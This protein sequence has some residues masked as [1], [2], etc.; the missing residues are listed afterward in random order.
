MFKNKFCILLCFVVSVMAGHVIAMDEENSSDGQNQQLFILPG[1]Q[2]IAYRSPRSTW[3]SLPFLASFTQALPGGQ[4]HAISNNNLQEDE[5]GC[6]VEP[7]KDDSFRGNDVGLQVTQK[8]KRRCAD[9]FEQNEEDEF[10]CP[11]NCPDEYAHKK[12]Y[13]V[14]RHIKARHNNDFN[15]QTFDRQTAELD[16][17]RPRKSN[18]SKS[19]KYMS[20]FERNETGEYICPY[21]CP[22]NYT[23]KKG[24]L[25]VA[26]IKRRH[27]KNFNLQTFDSTKVDLS[28]WIPC[29]KDGSYAEFKKNE[30]CEFVCPYNCPDNYAHK[31]KVYVYVHIRR[32]H[33]K[34]FNL[35]TFDRQTADLDAWI[36][37]K[38]RENK[39][40][41]YVGVFEQNEIGEFKCPYNCPDEYA[42]KKGYDVVCHI[43]ARHDKSFNVETFDR[44]TVDLEVWIPRKSRENKNE[45]YVGVF[46]QNE[47]V[48]FKCPYNCPDNYAHEHGKSLVA[49]IKRRHDPAF[50]LQTFNIDVVDLNAWI[51]RKQGGHKKRYVDV[52][53]KNERDEFVCPYNCS[54]EYTHKNGKM[55]VQHI[56]RRH[57]PEFDM[58]TFDPETA[59]LN[60]WI[61]RGKKKKYTDVL[62][63]NENGEFECPFNCPVRYVNKYG[64]N[65]IQ[66]IKARHDKDIDLQNFDKDKADLDTWILWKQTWKKRYKDVLEK[67]QE[68]EF[69]CPYNCP[70]NYTHK[71]GR[72]IVQ[73]IKRR[74]DS[75]FDLESFDRVLAN[76]D[77]W[78]PRKKTG[79]RKR[80]RSTSSAGSNRL[81]KKRKLKI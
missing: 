68:D 13:N 67:N 16:A 1:A 59:N 32:R 55:V 28:A 36:P 34:E 11:Y 38:S 70:E 19:K 35:Q 22:N 65:V 54:N 29:I 61:P 23:H 10:K 17:W 8:K 52:F 15:L 3:M 72:I 75:N 40:E 30:R 50:D 49:H 51:P 45:K 80:K 71:K 4:L 42:H 9:V 6:E 24:Q 81:K 48:E 43:K 56:K 79:G 63:K 33:D 47:I 14:V 20:A 62:M 21:I 78:I 76:L 18:G 37:R 39:S 69:E 73:H 46:E 58:Q 25:V 60:A 7:D 57:N 74:H 12:E 5:V 64:S 26:H 77:A 2:N 44:Q 27:D 53:E 66:H 31:S 41:K